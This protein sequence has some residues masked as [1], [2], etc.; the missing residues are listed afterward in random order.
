MKA[1]FAAIFITA[2]GVNVAGNAINGTVEA[3]E[4]QNN[5]RTEQ[6]CQ[7]NARYCA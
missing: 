3:L 7:I 4:Q 5:A 1:L 6:L 2:V